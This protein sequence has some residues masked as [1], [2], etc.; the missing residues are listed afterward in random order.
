MCSHCWPSRAPSLPSPPLTVRGRRGLAKGNCAAFL[1][2][3]SG[4]GREGSGCSGGLSS[5]LKW[6]HHLPRCLS[7]LSHLRQCLFTA[8]FKVLVVWVLKLARNVQPRRPG[9]GGSMVTPSPQ[10]SHVNQEPHGSRLGQED[11]P[12]ALGLV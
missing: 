9:A 8:P 7:F 1:M 11:G 12:R 10:L 3:R 6:P 5:P 2:R 4:R